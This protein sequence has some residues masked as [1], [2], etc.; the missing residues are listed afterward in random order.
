M[1]TDPSLSLCLARS[2][3]LLRPGRL[4]Y[5]LI[6]TFASSPSLE[7]HSTFGPEELDER[8]KEVGKKIPKDMEGEEVVDC[9]LTAKWVAKETRETKKRR[10]T[11][12]V[13][14]GEGEWVEWSSEEEEEEVEA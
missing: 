10:V 14:L 12:R 11:R 9:W 4:A 2:S 3:P 6:T 5:T 7:I 13:D 8:L 1:I